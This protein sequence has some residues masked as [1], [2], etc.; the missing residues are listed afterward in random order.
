MNIYQQWKKL[1][2][3]HKLAAKHEWYDVLSQ[4]NELTE[5]QEND[6]FGYYYKGIGN[7]ELKLFDEAFENFEIALVNVKKNR[8]PKFV[9]EYQQEIELRL[10]N[11]F[12]SQ[13]MYEPAL[14]RLNQLIERY[15]KYLAAYKSKAGIY[16]DLEQLQRALDTTNEGLRHHPT[17]Q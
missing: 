4:A 15:P 10:A 5:G 9:E 7:T 1:Q 2:Q 6:F 3:V 17:D 8:F 12:R 13:R 14:E 16:I 11:L